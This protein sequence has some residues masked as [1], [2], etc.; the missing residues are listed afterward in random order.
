MHASVLGNCCIKT[1]L[2]SLI[3][4]RTCE[5]EEYYNFYPGCGRGENWTGEGQQ[6]C[7]N[8]GR[9][10]QCA[11]PARDISTA[12]I[13]LAEL[14]DCHVRDSHTFSPSWVGN[15]WSQI[16][17]GMK[18]LRELL[19]FYKLIWT[20]VTMYFFFKAPEYDFCRKSFVLI[21]YISVAIYFDVFLNA[22]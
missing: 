15:W 17:K 22:K 3:G 18:T 5:T 4:W 19:F 12:E 7:R 1:L 9:N 14:R 20:S 10:H 21:F 16:S 13:N 8:L 2:A 11:Q 6:V